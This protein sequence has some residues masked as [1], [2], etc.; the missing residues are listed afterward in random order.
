MK[1]YV[2][3]TENRTGGASLSN[4]KWSDR[5]DTRVDFQLVGVS[6]VEPTDWYKEPF[7]LD[8][9]DLPNIIYVVLVRY[10]DGDSFGSSYGNGHIEGIYS[11]ED[12]AQKIVESI[13]NKTYTKN[14]YVPWEGYF[15]KLISVNY[16]PMMVR[17]YPIVK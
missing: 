6:V 15:N 4:E 7:D 11:S 16:H 8:C 13:R 9:Q 3:Y 5:E 10:K 1:I 14:I 12:E 2:S 17:K